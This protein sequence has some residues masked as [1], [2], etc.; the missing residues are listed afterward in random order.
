MLNLVNYPTNIGFKVDCINSFAKYYFHILTTR[1]YNKQDKTPKHLII[2]N[3]KQFL[4]TS[5]SFNPFAFV[6][7]T[8]DFIQSRGEALKS[9]IRSRQRNLLIRVYADSHISLRI[10]QNELLNPPA[11]GMVRNTKKVL[12]PCSLLLYPTSHY[13]LPEAQ[14][15][16]A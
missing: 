13:S 3:L 9:S 11:V 6:F 12:A 5:K 8:S 16:K 4:A 2:N 14:S 1:I 10:S 7:V 15:A